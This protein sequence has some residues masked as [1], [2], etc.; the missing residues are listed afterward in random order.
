[1]SE[2]TEFEKEIQKLVSTSMGR[3]AFLA[4]LPALAV[5]CSSVEKT[6]YREGDNTGQAA[7]LTVA[8]E[9]QMTQE[10]LAQM[11]KDYPPV[12][13]AHLQNYIN[14]LGQKIVRANGYNGNPY[15]YRFAV[16]ESSMLNAFALPAGTVFVTSELV[17]KAETEAELAGVVGH[18]VGH[19]KA[20][21]SAE[22]I[23]VQKSSAGKTAAYT[24]GGGLLGGLLGYG[25]GSIICAK[26]D[27]SCKSSA[28]QMGVSVGAVG[29]AIL[30]KY[31]FLAHSREDEMEADRIGFKTSVKAGYD[32]N[33]VGKFYE[34]LLTMEGGK[35]PSFTD[36]LS[37][38]PP[39]RERVQQMQEMAS[40]V[41]TRG[42]VSSTHFE[43]M[44]RRAQAIVPRA[45]S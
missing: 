7:G 16:V 31:S 19:V 28:A 9:R 43:Q 35:Q 38:H 45:Q 27:S 36:A 18:E 42:R 14:G 33:H 21:H 44:R 2:I 39:S 8:Q 22:R 40:Q 20:R 25:L 30:S 5:A 23:L 26:G 13:D 34:K 4:A 10:Y 12:R 37:T 15:N 41:A 29:S 17:A 1:M 32:K 3:R 6:R 24:I 11:Q